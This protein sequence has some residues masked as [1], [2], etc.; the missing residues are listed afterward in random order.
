MLTG[1]PQT[2]DHPMHP[3]VIDSTG[4]LFINSGSETNVCEKPAHALGAMGR[5]PCPELP[6]RAGIWKYDAKQV[7][8]EVLG[9]E[10]LHHRVAQFPAAR[11]SMPAAGCSL[12]STDATVAGELPQALHD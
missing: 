10:P 9:E 6:T 7:G 12:Y 5:K 8:A 4:N 3:F 1:L 2:G 11:P